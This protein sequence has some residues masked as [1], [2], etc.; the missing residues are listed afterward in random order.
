[1]S[2]YDTNSV[3][4]LVN[5]GK[6]AVEIQLAIR[7]LQERVRDEQDKLK[8]VLDEC[9]P[10]MDG[11]IENMSVDA[12]T[13]LHIARTAAPL[14]HTRQRMQSIF[15]RIARGDFPDVPPLPEAHVQAILNLIFTPHDGIDDLK[16]KTAVVLRPDGAQAKRGRDDA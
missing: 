4:R 5:L 15:E 6:R 3:A 10:L 12:G 8:K 1:M 14:R 13:K 7:K 16:T 9:L 2:V 11:N